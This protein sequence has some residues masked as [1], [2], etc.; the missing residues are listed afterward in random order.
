MIKGAFVAELNIEVL[1]AL[2][3]CLHFVSPQW[4]LRLFGYK[5]SCWRTWLWLSLP[6]FHGLYSLVFEIPWFWSSVDNNF[7]FN[8]HHGYANEM[9]PEVI[10]N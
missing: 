9:F 2:N 8:P 3:R 6:L 7:M 1:L 5:E 10:L 4:A